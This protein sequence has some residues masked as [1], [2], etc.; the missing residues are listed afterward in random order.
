[1]RRGRIASPRQ[2]FLSPGFTSQGSYLR[3]S[4]PSLRSRPTRAHRAGSDLHPQTPLG[5][6]R[7]AIVHSV[8]RPSP[9]KVGYQAG[10]DY[11]SQL[12][13]FTTPKKQGVAVVGFEVKG[14]LPSASR[15]Y[16]S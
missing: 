1:M 8:I 9:E 3:G 2:Y 14:S 11:M 7:P 12:F 15:W 13:K 4:W 10:K 6:G 16:L 5:K